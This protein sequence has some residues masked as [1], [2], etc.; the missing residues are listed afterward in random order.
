MALDSE[1][2]HNAEKYL[3]M[4]LAINATNAVDH[5]NLG[6]VYL[7]QKKDAL[8]I[9]SFEKAQQLGRENVELLESL[10]SAYTKM[11]DYDAASKC[12]NACWVSTAATSAHFHRSANSITAR[13]ILTKRSPTTRKS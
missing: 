2:L 10:G 3:E 11:R 9:K 7:R 8:A 4:A 1:D 6:I 5:Y 13:G 12:T